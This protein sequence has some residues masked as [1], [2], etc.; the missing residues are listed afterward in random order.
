M[1]LLHITTLLQE[2]LKRWC[3]LL[4]P[5]FL[6][7]AGCG[8]QTP[9]V[10]IETDMGTRSDIPP[11]TRSP[12]QRIGARL[13]PQGF[14][15]L[16]ALP[17]YGTI[18]NFRRT[19]LRTGCSG[20]PSHITGFRSFRLWGFRR[21]CARNAASNDSKAVVGAIW[22]I[23]ARGQY[24]KKFLKIFRRL[25]KVARLKTGMMS[26]LWIDLWSRILQVSCYFLWLGLFF[27]W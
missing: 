13:F 9:I 7:L 22:R 6:L 2:Y 1:A 26:K 16:E 21:N 19:H 8:Q 3:C 25:G 27:W 17:E 18:E 4:L 10:R 5:V 12:G 15:G 24:R 20:L 23:F 11:Q 14:I